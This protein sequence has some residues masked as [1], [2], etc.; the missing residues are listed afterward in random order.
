MGDAFLSKIIY[1]CILTAIVCGAGTTLGSVITVIFK[2]SDDLVVSAIMGM[3]GGLMLSVTTFDLIPE[4]ILSGGI[5]LTLIGIALGV[6]LVT[7][8]D[9]ILPNTPMIISKGTQLKTAILLGL[10]LAFHN[11][12]EGLAIGSGF[13]GNNTLGAE[14]L[15]VIGL[16]DLP[17]GAAVASPLLKS[18][19][20]G[21]RI[22][23]ITFLT[24]LPTILGAYIGARLGSISPV[25]VTLCLGFAA[26]TM[27]YIICGE[28]IPE[29]KKLS[30]G[31]FSTICIIVGVIMGLWIINMM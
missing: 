27:L 25:F 15:L 24:A 7:I 17:E 3:T 26:G 10:G 9:V 20:P 4:A 6:I 13:A 28:L 31:V 23:F 22:I 16:H 19:L 21:G 12:P 2:N 29:S 1:A 11:F 30:H 14:L 18:S 5:A 8:L